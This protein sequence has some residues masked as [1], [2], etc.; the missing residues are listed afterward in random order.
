[1]DASI[2]LRDIV[3]PALDGCAH[4]HH[5]SRLIFNAS[6]EIDSLAERIAALREHDVPDDVI[7]A[8][9]ADLRALRESNH[10]ELAAHRA[11]AKTGDNLARS[12]GSARAGLCASL[13]DHMTVTGIKRRLGGGDGPLAILAAPAGRDAK[14][15]MGAQA[16]VRDVVTRAPD[17][18]LNRPSLRNQLGASRHDLLLALRAEWG[19]NAS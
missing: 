12:A 17:A 15:L 3:G 4:N 19:R 10:A 8:L 2:L 7:S 5:Q 18:V 9:F 11:V 16:A 14:T 1:M 13:P 6:P